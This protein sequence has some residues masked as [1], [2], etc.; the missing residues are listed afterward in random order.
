MVLTKKNKALIKSLCENHSVEKLYLFGS[1][2]TKAFSKNSDIDFLVKFRKIDLE[3]YFDNYIT[4]KE[5]L[6]NIFKREV[7]LVE[8]QTLKNPILINSINKNKEL[9]YG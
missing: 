3:K 1:A 4:L 5:A 2:T 9:I 8:E 6:K 7:D